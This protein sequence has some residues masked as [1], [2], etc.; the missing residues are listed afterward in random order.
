MLK[1][2]MGKELDLYI[3]QLKPAI[4]KVQSFLDAYTKT[5]G[6]WRRYAH[7]KTDDQ[8]LKDIADSDVKSLEQL[9]YAAE[10]LQDHLNN[11][12]KLREE[13]RG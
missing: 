12:V 5:A 1:S 4:E 8:E 7:E 6:F 2:R 3:G 9:R 13:L 10:W 11:L